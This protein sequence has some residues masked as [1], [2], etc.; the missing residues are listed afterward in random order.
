MS[1]NSLCR[2]G[3]MKIKQDQARLMWSRQSTWP[4]VWFHTRAALGSGLGLDLSLPEFPYLLS[5]SPAV[6][7]SQ[8]RL[9]KAVA[10]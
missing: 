1:G 2:G 6:Q 7:G 10:P 9:S 8:A 5:R 4:V 3:W